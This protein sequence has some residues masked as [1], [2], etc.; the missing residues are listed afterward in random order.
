VL[1]V[2]AG[3]ISDTMMLYSQNS[4][5]AQHDEKGQH[6]KRHTCKCC[7]DANTSKPKQACLMSVS[8]WVSDEAPQNISL[9]V[10]SIASNPLRGM[11]E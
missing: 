4:S 5:K 1:L 8:K 3:R 2:H 9:N 11:D 6:D 7:N 10:N